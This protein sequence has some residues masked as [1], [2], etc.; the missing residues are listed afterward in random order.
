[1]VS[2]GFLYQS[3]SKPRPEGCVNIS[4]VGVASVRNKRGWSVE[5]QGGRLA[6][7]SVAGCFVPSAHLARECSRPTT[8]FLSNFI[9]EEV[10]EFKEY[11]NS[12]GL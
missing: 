10:S 1:M 11:Q 9:N 5:G 8:G 6:M 2:K 4:Q 3:T 12:Y 7:P